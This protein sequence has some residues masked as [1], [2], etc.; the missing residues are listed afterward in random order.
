MIKSHNRCCLYLF[1]FFLAEALCLAA[2]GPNVL[3]DSG[4]ERSG[5]TEFFGWTNTS[6]DGAVAEP[7]STVFRSGAKSAK[8]MMIAGS[9]A[10]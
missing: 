3:I 4:F 6:V 7:D 5:A 1:V 8:F 9:K 2:T 10:E